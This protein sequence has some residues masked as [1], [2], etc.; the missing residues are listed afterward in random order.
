MY[1]VSIR[2]S[3]KPKTNGGNKTGQDQPPFGIR[4]ST[5]V[6]PKNSTIRPSSFIH[7]PSSIVF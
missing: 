5:I 3:S 1:F 2:E 4:Q 7:L 6:I